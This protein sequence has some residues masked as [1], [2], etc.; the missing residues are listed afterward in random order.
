MNAT[1]MIKALLIAAKLEERWEVMRRLHG[2][3]WESV[4]V[5]YEPY[6][7]SRMK[8]DACDIL[9]AALTLGTI[10]SDAGECPNTLFAVAVE[11]MK[12]E[13]RTEKAILK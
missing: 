9:P 10:L 4:V 3:R 13:E 8:A 2:E 5:E 12:R 1:A 6:I 7:R 11:L